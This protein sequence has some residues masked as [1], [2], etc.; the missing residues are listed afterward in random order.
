[1]R[2][3]IQYLSDWGQRSGQRYSRGRG[4]ERERKLLQCCRLSTFPL[5]TLVCR[6]SSSSNAACSRV[7][8]LPRSLSLSLFCWLF[9]QFLALL[10][11]DHHHRRTLDPDALNHNKWFTD[12]PFSHYHHHCYQSGPRRDTSLIVRLLY[13]ALLTVFCLPR[14]RCSFA[15]CTSKLCVLRFTLEHRFSGST[16]KWSQTLS[17]SF[18][19]IASSA[20]CAILLSILSNSS[21]YQQETTF[22]LPT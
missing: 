16:S 11:D 12:Y 13:R 18:L 5:G 10:L 17:L 2:T 9:T 6:C 1:M 14:R 3:A 21:N 22:S 20:V 7:L 4:R 8:T 15:S 19:I